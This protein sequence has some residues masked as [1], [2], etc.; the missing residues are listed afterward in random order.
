MTSPTIPGGADQPIDAGGTFGDKQFEQ[1]ALA[2]ANADEAG[3]GT[4]SFKRCEML[5]PFKPFN[6]FFLVDQAT[7]T[8]T[9]LAKLCFGAH[10]CLHAEHT[11]WQAIRRNGNQAMHHEATRITSRAVTPPLGGRQMRKVEFGRVL[12]SQDNRY[13]L[14]AIQRLRNVRREYSVRID[15]GIVEESVRGLEFRWFEGLGKRTLRCA[16]EPTRQSDK[17]PHQ[18]CVAKIRFAELGTWPIIAVVVARQYRCKQ[19]AQKLTLGQLV[20]KRIVQPSLGNVGNPEPKGGGVHSIST[21]M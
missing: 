20:Y 13:L 12:H 14:H 4:A 18:T 16:S 19:Y 1:V 2:I 10:P 7:F 3:V 15:L 11:Q 17:S 21:H 6:A 8:L 5:D 9:C